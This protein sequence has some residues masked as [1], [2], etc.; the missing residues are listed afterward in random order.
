[1]D[2]YLSRLSEF[3]KSIAFFE[4]GTTVTFDE[5]LGII[6]NFET[7]LTTKGVKAGDVVIVDGKSN[8]DFFAAVIAV[9]HLGAIA[10]PLTDLASVNHSVAIQVSNAHYRLFTDG[11]RIENLPTQRGVLDTS[12]LLKELQ[13][14]KLGGLIL[15]SSGS[16][17][18]PKGIL[19]DVN[20]LLEKFRNVR[21]PIKALSFLLLD[22]FGGLNTVLAITSSGGEVITLIDRSVDTVCS[23]VEKHRV[24]ILP[25]TPSFLR[26]LLASNAHRRFDLSSLQKI[27]FGTEPMT[28]STLM[29]LRSEFPLVELQQ[30]YGLSEVGVLRSKS[31]PDGSLWMKVGGEGFQW[32]I[33]NGTLWIN[34]EFRMRGYLNA[35]AD[36]DEQGFFNT[37]DEVLVD[38]EYIQVLG[39]VSDIINVGGEKVYPAEVE[40]A[41]LQLEN[42]C[43]VV[44]YGVANPLL[45]Q[46]I[47]VDV[48][49]ENPEEIKDLRNRIRN[50]CRI[51]I[52]KSRTPTNIRIVE[53]IELSGRQK[54]KRPIDG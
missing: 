47:S 31:R 13:Q 9:M 44:A 6:S 24:S 7:V 42:I 32:K 19:Y 22:H 14:Q 50:H 43:Q 29:K 52:G 37:Q 10:V 51:A 3:G 5:L 34:S 20:C 25:V 48:V 40:S 2:W 33:K 36:F 49:L 53:A 28:E 26:L 11:N 39:R 38:G 8:C 4:S 35:D 12:P 45:G 1:M 15:F 54:T 21:Q 16:S 30:T 27:T 23:A 46:T 41:V 17:G 18:T